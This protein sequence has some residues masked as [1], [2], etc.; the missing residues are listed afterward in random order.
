MTSRLATAPVARP[1]DGS[2]PAFVPRH[3]PVALLGLLNVSPLLAWLFGLGSFS[4]WFLAVAAPALVLLGAVGTWSARRRPSLHVVLVV[5][6]IGGLLGI[7]GYDV[8]RLPVAAAGQQ[9]FA[10]IDSYG[11]LL[12]DAVSSSPWTGIAGWAFHVGN[13]VGFALAYAVVALGRSWWWA[14]IWAMV[15]ETATV[16]T[17]FATVYGLAGHPWLIALAYAAHIAYGAPLGYVVQ[18]GPRWYGLLREVSPRTTTYALLAVAASI[19]VWQHPWSPA[20]AVQ[21]GEA[22]APGASGVIRGG[23][24]SPHWL[25][26][27]SGRCAVV[28]NDDDKPVSLRSKQVAALPTIPP[29]GTGRACGGH[30]RVA[31]RVRVDG[32]PWS[33]GFLLVDPEEGRP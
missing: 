10:P 31:A 3:L 32:R 33:G 25:R 23:H 7:A 14:V 12:L 17:P 28:R 5:G 9:V 4:A 2:A 8:V 1:A 11:V 13:G 16:V 20:P 29:D 27:A 21:A 19:V 24:L 6:V 26:V 18:H 30:V 15:L 22:V